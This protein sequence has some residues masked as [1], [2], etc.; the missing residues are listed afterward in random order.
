MSVILSG[1]RIA[2]AQLPAVVEDHEKH[3][4]L[5]RHH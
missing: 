1:L 5:N 2:I 4:H 3:I